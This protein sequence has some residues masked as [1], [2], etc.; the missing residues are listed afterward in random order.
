[1]WI[2]CSA[3]DN[4]PHDK[5]VIHMMHALRWVTLNFTLVNLLG[6]DAVRDW[7]LAVTIIDAIV[8]YFKAWEFF[9]VRPWWSIIWKADYRVH[10]TAIADLHAIGEQLVD[11]YEQRHQNSKAGVRMFLDCFVL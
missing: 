9:F 4:V 6:L 1:M 8:A 3:I 2:L 7:K 11:N 10:R 5:G